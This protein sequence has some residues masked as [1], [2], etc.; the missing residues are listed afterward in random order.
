MGATTTRRQSAARSCRSTWPLAI[1]GADRRADPLELAR[2]RAQAV[3]ELVAR[4]VQRVRVVE[5]PDH[6]LDRALDERLAIDVAARVALGDRPVRV[7]ERLEGID[8][9][10][11]WRARGQRG[12]APQRPARDEQRAASEDG[13]TIATATRTALGSRP[14]GAGPM[15]GAG[16]TADRVVDGGPRVA[17]RPSWRDRPAGRG[18]ALAV[19][20]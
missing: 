19:I 20:E 7:P 12:L 3:L 18:P 9:L 14:R 10:A 13:T 2:D 16:A 8:L 4:E 1:D 11:G 5:R 15:T 17:R 6:A